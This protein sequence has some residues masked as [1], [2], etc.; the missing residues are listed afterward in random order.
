ML[1][2]GIY[3]LENYLR[4]D[5]HVASSVFFGQSPLD[6]HVDFDFENDIILLR[7]KLYYLYPQLTI[8]EAVKRCTDGVFRI[9][10][11]LGI[12]TNID[13]GEPE[14]SEVAGTLLLF[15]FHKGFNRGDLDIKSLV[16][17]AKRIEIEGTTNRGIGTKDAIK[18][19]ASLASGTPS[20]SID[21]DMIDLEP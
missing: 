3:R 9:R 15:F 4:Y 19:Q 10:E 11:I 17:I 1:D 8:E 18:C 6:I 20:V 2:W 21:Q 13:T 12:D 16:D 7:F 14:R 5:V